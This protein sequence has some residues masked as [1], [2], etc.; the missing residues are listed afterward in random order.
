MRQAAKR[1]KAIYTAINHRNIAQAV[2]L[3]D[4][5]CR[6]EDLNF[7]ATFIGRAAVKTLPRHIY[8]VMPGSSGR[9]TV[10]H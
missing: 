5:Q 8:R 10:C 6:Y 1:I 7:S 2:T 4:G 3:I 9:S